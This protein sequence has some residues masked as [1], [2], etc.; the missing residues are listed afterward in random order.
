MNRVSYIL[1]DYLQALT[2][3]YAEN[4]RKTWH[5]LPA[6]FILALY[7]FLQW[8]FSNFRISPENLNLEPLTI[9]NDVGH[10]VLTI[11]YDARHPVS[12]IQYDVG[13]PVLT[14]QYD[15]GH[16]A[17]TIQYDVGH[18]VLH[19]FMVISAFCLKRVF[20]KNERAYRFTAK[21][22]RF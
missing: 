19:F 18:P 4:T 5:F 16:P 2:P 11:Q 1:L 17:L 22:N 21:N 20:A 14:I 8:F 7:N 13:H 12:T 9:Q 6:N 10:S 3:K 15:L